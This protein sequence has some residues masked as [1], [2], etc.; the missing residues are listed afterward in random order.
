MLGTDTTAISEGQS[1]NSQKNLVLQRRLLYYAHHPQF[2]SHRLQQLDRETSQEKIIE[3]SS[4]GLS[5]TGNTIGFCKSEMAYSFLV[6]FR[7]LFF[8]ECVQKQPIVTTSSG[9]RLSVGERNI[10]GTTDFAGASG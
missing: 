3:N 8:K 7:T 9:T 10:P 6:S 5:V 2:I 4:V 1:E